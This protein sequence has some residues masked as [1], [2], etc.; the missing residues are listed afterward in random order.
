MAHDGEK[1]L[2]S[3]S[4]SLT[5][6]RCTAMASI[7]HLHDKTLYKSMYFERLKCGGKWGRG[8]EGLGVIH[9]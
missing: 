7:L 5:A 1:S 4:S 9:A 3:G 6:A 8:G 2:P